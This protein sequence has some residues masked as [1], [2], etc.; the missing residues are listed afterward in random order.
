M[1]NGFAIKIND[2]LYKSSV[3]KYEYYFKNKLR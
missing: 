3:I 2:N 1:K